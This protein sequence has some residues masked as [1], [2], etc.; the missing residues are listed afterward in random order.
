MSMGDP[1][2][3]A[4]ELGAILES[5][6]R[7]RFGVELGYTGRQALEYDP[8]RSVAPGFFALTALGD[9]RLGHPEQTHHD[10]LLRPSPGPGGIPMTD[11][12]APL[13]GRTY[14]GIHSDL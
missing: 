6:K 2:L 11:V 8:N 1:S 12:W 7:G 4:T 9:I 10:P 14:L 13:G 3:Q 5:E